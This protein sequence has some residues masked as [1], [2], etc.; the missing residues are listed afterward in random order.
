MNK[1]RKDYESFKESIKDLARWIDIDYQPY[2]EKY[3]NLNLQ[4][5]Q[6][7]RE[8]ES[9]RERENSIKQSLYNIRLEPLQD[10]K[11]DVYE[12]IKHKP[13]KRAVL[14]FLFTEGYITNKVMDACL[15]KMWEDRGAYKLQYNNP[16]EEQG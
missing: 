16:Y 2:I 5:E 15:N 11:L 14:D 7:D 8:K 1:H 3:R 9:I 6:I 4:L 13:N 10:I 12:F